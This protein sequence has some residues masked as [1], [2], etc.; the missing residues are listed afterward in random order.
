MRFASV[1]FA[2]L[3][4][5][6]GCCEH[7]KCTPA[8]KLVI[9]DGAGRAIPGATASGVPTLMACAPADDCSYRFRGDGTITVAAE[10]YKPATVAVTT[11]MDDCD[12]VVAQSVEVTLAPAAEAVETT[13]RTLV[14]SADCQ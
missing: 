1:M 8:S 10:G 14:L 9:R 5:V 12:R 7:H 6:A 2:S 3:L 11:R 4:G 13:S